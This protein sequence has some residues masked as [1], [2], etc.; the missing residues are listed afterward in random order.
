MLCGLIIFLAGVIA[1]KYPAKTGYGI[2]YIEVQRFEQA[3][4]LV[5]SEDLSQ[6]ITVEKR[7]ALLNDL[8]LHL[9]ITTQ[10]ETERMVLTDDLIIRM[11]DMMQDFIKISKANPKKYHQE[12]LDEF[13]ER[14][15]NLKADSD[16][17][18]L[19]NQYAG[20]IA[21]FGMLLYFFG[22]LMRLRYD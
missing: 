10:S 15:E 12:Y 6:K 19:E 9:K 4:F 18:F 14:F 13:K 7:Q 2:S 8:T 22:A 3:A 16:S 1:G 11:K 17:V 21:L 5:H 20:Y